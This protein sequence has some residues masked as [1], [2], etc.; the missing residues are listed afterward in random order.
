MSVIFIRLIGQNPR[1]HKKLAK[2][3]QPEKEVKMHVAMTNSKSFGKE[4]VWMFQLNTLGEMT[5]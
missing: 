2:L 3:P 5:A 4:L 1:K